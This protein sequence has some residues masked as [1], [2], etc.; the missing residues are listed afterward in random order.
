MPAIKEE[1]TDDQMK[2]IIAYE[3]LVLNFPAH[4]V[5]VN[6][7]VNKYWHITQN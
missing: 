2:E 6:R 3:R 4:Y 1:E 7:E 5:H